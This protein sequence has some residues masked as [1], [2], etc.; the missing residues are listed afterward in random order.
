MHLNQYDCGVVQAAYQVTTDPG[1]DKAEGQHS[2]LEELRA[3]VRG[4][5][6][7]PLGQH[8]PGQSHGHCQT[9]SESQGHPVSA[10]LSVS[11][12]QQADLLRKVRTTHGS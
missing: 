2:E 11:S 10:R 1:S 8:T 4:Q 7:Q 9:S 6:A 12:A 3:A 5:E